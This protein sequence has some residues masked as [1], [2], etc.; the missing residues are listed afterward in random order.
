MAPN[1][2][3]AN[4]QEMM[5]QMIHKAS[6]LFY[7]GGKPKVFGQYALVAQIIEVPGSV[8]NGNLSPVSD[9][10]MG[11]EATSGL[12]RLPNRIAR[13]FSLGH[14]LGHGFGEKITSDIGLAGISGTATEVIA[15]LTSAYLLNQL[16]VLWDR[17]LAALRSAKATLFDQAQ[18]GNH[19][20]GDVR[21]AN[22]GSLMQYLKNG[23]TFQEAAK[24]IL[25]S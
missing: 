4:A 1:V 13:D 9:S 25:T 10:Q 15:D 21:I 16:G 12:I 3:L 6:Q 20:P 7:G 19:P 11:V 22:I 5:R 8:P 14:E 23:S 17:L 18:S 24:S 2:E